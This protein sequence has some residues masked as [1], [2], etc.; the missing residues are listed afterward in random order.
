MYA[1]DNMAVNRLD[2]LTGRTPITV[3]Y[4]PGALEIVE[5]HDGSRIALRKIA[6][7][8]DRHGPAEGDE[9]SAGKR[10]RR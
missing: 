1:S 9:L 6:P 4:A 7:N 2:F 3:D 5:Q 10:G 8:Y